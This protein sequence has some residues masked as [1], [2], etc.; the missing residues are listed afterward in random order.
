MVYV[1]KAFRVSVVSL[2]KDPRG[3]IAAV[4]ISRLLRVSLKSRWEFKYLEHQYLLKL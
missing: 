4:N 3:D 2:R 1:T